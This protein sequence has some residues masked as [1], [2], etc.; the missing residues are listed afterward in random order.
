MQFE[1]LVLPRLRIEILS[2]QK[3]LFHSAFSIF[4]GD[5]TT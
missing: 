4:P 1:N 5:H 2:L 3:A